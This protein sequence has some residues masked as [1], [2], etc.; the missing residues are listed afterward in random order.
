MQVLDVREDM[1]KL[2]EDIHNLKQEMAK[3]LHALRSKKEA[4]DSSQ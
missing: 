4:A 3:T 2:K 1:N